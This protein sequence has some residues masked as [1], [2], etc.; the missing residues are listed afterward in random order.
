[1][2]KKH[3]RNL[4]KVQDMLDDKLE[5]KIQSG[6]VVVEETHKVGDKWTDSDGVEWEQ[7][8]GYRSKVSK[9]GNVGIFSKQCKDCNKSCSLGDRNT[10]TF[11]RMG[12]CFGCQVNFEVDLKKLNT[13]KAQF[14]KLNAIGGTEA[15]VPSEGIVFKYN[16][17]TYKFTGAFAPINQITGLI[18]F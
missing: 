7:K 3:S 5:R 1:M 4:Q 11:N 9:M 16:G 2:A 10:D 6:Y 8:N 18:S 12:R 14:D 15:I 17:K 13:L